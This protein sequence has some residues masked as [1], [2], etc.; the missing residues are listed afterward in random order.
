MRFCATLHEPTTRAISRPFAKCN[1]HRQLSLAI[2]Y[3]P[4]DLLTLRLMA[5]LFLD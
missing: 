4:T 1:Q 2:V 3:T 5:M